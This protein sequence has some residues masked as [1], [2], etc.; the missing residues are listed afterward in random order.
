[1]Q[2]VLDSFYKKT[3]TACFNKPG[4][5]PLQHPDEII[6][7]YNKHILTFYL[8]VIIFTQ[9]GVMDVAV[10]APQ[11]NLS[12]SYYRQRK[13]GTV[14]TGKIKKLVETKPEKKGRCRCR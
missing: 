14:E 8:I 4:E 7:I 5:V 2:I 11:S 3:H 9:A 13:N 6:E 1:M 10:L 12:T